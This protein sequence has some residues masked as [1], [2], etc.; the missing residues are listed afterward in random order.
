MG[1]HHFIAFHEWSLDNVEDALQKM[2]ACIDSAAE[3][4]IPPEV[5]PEKVKQIAKQ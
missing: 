5:D 4:L 2:Q 1:V 3:S